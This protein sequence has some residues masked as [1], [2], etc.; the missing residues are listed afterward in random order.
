M[1]G[2]TRITMRTGKEE[3]EEDVSSADVHSLSLYQE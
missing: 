3:N 1:A 2:S